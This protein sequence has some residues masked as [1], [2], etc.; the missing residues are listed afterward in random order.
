MLIRHLLTAALL[1]TALPWRLPA[2]EAPGLTLREVQAFALE[3]A[4]GLARQRLSYDN[5][6]EAVEIARA[7]FDP[8]FTA[9]QEWRDSTGTWRSEA[10]VR[11]TLPGDLN[12]TGTLA[13]QEAPD[14]NDL[15]TAALR[16]SKV[17]LGGGS[18]RESF[19]GLDR[20]R[21]QEARELNRLSLEQRRLLLTV[22]RQFFEVVRSE[23]TLQLRQLQL[24]R[25]RVNLEH[26][27]VREDPL[28]IATARLRIPESE[29]EVERAERAITLGLLTLKNEI[30]FPLDQPLLLATEVPFDVRPLNAAQ[31]AIDIGRALENHEQVLNARLDTRLAQKEFQVARTQRLPQVRAELSVQNREERLISDSETDTRGEIIVTWPWLDRRDRAQ[32]RQRENDLRSAE[33]AL[34]QVE[35]DRRR[36]ITSLASRVREAEITVRLQDERVAVLEQQLRL[37]QD[38]WENGEIGILEYVRSQNTLE[39]AR[40][41]ALTQRLR[42]LELLAEYDFSVG[43]AIPPSEATP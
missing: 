24:E 6:L 29:L 33:I 36:D 42:Y 5:F 31:E 19:L 22:T 37:F 11:Q 40:V 2:E 16:L 3:H 12:I 7:K 9:R 34:Q 10:G 18:I 28:D 38:R 41:Q 32:F 8:T 20:A 26:A 25:A 30:G 21:I 13:Y 23:Q 17:L 1:L 15:T 39:D 4:P 14:G 27:L 43:P 35:N